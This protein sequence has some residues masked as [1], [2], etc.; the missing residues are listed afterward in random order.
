MISSGEKR[1][2]E[3]GADAL[4]LSRETPHPH[5]PF[6]GGQQSRGQPS[7]PSACLS[8]GEGAE[9][10]WSEGQTCWRRAG[11]ER[12]TGSSQHGLLGRDVPV[13]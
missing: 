7:A 13:S 6:L 11:A 2:E 3:N 5:V 9:S 10:Q 12:V 4:S 8:M 1:K